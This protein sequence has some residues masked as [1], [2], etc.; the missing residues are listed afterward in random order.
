MAAVLVM[1]HQRLDTT[2]EEQRFQVDDRYS[3]TRKHYRTE[4]QAPPNGKQ[5]NQKHWSLL[6][7]I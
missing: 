2:L 5:T 4:R 1:M 3:A 7:T 6:G